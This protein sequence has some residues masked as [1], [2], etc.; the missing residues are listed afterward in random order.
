MSYLLLSIPS[1]SSGVLEIGPIPLRAYGICIA[2][3]VIA[4][5]WLA[6]RRWEE[7]GHNPDD[8]AAV[9]MWAVPAGVV[10]GRV[11]HVI[12]DN[13]RFRGQW[14]EAVKIWEGG[15]G[16]WGAV[17]GGVIAAYVLARRRGFDLGDLFYATAPAIPLAQAIGRF[18]NW[19]NQELFGRPTDLVWG[20]EIDVS[21]RPTGFTQFETFHPTFLYES[22]WNLAVA[23][24]VIWVVP[25]LL[26]RLRLGYYFA[27]YVFLYTVGRLW[28]ELIRIDS[29]NRILGVR[30]NVW[31][32]I[33][34]GSIA[35]VAIWWGHREQSSEAAE[36]ASIS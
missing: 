6:Q 25:R 26:P 27:V 5:V 36:T 32:S 11:Y 7:R 31:T 23:A 8:M 33:T 35:L 17:A 2:L 9:A 20:L 16:V 30:V 13:Q 1:P 18:G 14:F 4:A 28:I 24:T 3:G 19:F 34:V 10:G 21:H 12:T 15:L 22:L 29:A